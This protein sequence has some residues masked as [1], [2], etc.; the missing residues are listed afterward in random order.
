MHLYEAQKEV[1]NYI[2]QFKVGYFPPLANLARLMEEVGE[3][4][5]EINHHHGPKT[6]KASEDCRPEKIA[7]ELADIL[8]T[9]LTLA[10]QLE[11]D[12]DAAFSQ[13]IQK[14]LNRDSTRWEKTE[15]PE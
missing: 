13:S 9:V 8:F 7:E 11:V 12:M 1:H 14:Y 6:K 15:A 10:N 3:L 5:R 4:S 2:S